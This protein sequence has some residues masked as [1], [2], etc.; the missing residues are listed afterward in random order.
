MENRELRNAQENQFFAIMA[1]YGPIEEK[2]ED[3]ETTTTSKAPSKKLPP[4]NQE[5]R[6]KN[7]LREKEHKKEIL[8]DHKAK[9]FNNSPEGIFLQL[10][11][12]GKKRDLLTAKMV[13]FEKARRLAAENLKNQH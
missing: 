3:C 5:W 10:S 4:R 6:R 7:A 8:A 2:D 13:A 1:A 11:N 12:T 9:I